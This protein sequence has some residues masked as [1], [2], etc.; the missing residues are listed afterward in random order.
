MLCVLGGL[1]RLQFSFF[2]TFRV[3]ELSIQLIVRMCVRPLCTCA[4]V[5]VPTRRGGFWGRPLAPAL[6]FAACSREW[7]AVNCVVC[8]LRWYT[9]AFLRVSPAQSGPLAGCALLLMAVLLGIA[10]TQPFAVVV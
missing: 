4:R 8:P 7:T 10:L 1:C 6:V 5:Y 3:H 9:E 2:C